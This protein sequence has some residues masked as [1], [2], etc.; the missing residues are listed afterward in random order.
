LAVD[1]ARVWGS[2]VVC[3]EL[4]WGQLREDCMIHHGVNGRIILQ[5]IFKKSSGDWTGLKW[6][7]LGTGD[8]LV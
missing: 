7:R 3:T 2:E 5:W 4:W 1:V 6:P 8:G